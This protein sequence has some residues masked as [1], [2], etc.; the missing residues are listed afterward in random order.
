MR[1]NKCAKPLQTGG[2][3]MRNARQHTTSTASND[4]RFTPTLLVPAGICVV[5]ASRKKSISTVHRP[6]TG[7]KWG[8]KIGHNNDIKYRTLPLKLTKAR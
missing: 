5:T 1:L 7:I 4:L 2:V 6:W 8:K 3:A